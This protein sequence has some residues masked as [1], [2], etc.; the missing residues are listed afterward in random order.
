[1]PG[2]AKFVV[3]KKPATK[4]R[5]GINPFTQRADGLQGEA[6]PQGSEG[7]AGQSRQRRPLKRA[8]GA[9][10]PA[11]A[12]YWGPSWMG[13][14]AGTWRSGGRPSTCVEPLSAE[15]CQVQSMPDASPAKWHLAHTSWFFETFVLSGCREPAVVQRSAYLFNSYYE[16]VGPRHHAPRAAC[17]PARRWTRSASYRRRVD[18]AMLARSRARRWTTARVARAVLGLAPR[19]AASGADPHRRQAP[20]RR[21]SDRAGV[22]ARSAA[23]AAARRG[24]RPLALDRA[25]R[26]RRGDRRRRAGPT[27]EPFAF[28]NEARGTRCCCARTRSRRGW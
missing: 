25:A 10:G 9:P 27:G 4:E 12:L 21:Q 16:A 2:F 19:A 7:P 20:V 8:G 22:S 26:R 28:D 23:D 15:D 1:M 24:A 3:I 5:K 6:R 18:D 17:C 11:H 13:W 14:C